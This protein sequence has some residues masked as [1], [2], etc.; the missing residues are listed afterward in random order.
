MKL[1]LLFRRVKELNGNSQTS[2]A[3]K[4][5]EPMDSSTEEVRLHKMSP[6]S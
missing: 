1:D 4:A 6:T 2:G 5:Q 3:A